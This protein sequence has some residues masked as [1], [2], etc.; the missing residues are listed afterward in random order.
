MK[1]GD[2]VVCVSKPETNVTLVIG[3]VYTI[4]YM[5]DTFV[6]VDGN[7][8]RNFYP[9]RFKKIDDNALNRLLYPEAFDE[10]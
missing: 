9:I 6:Y 2:K 7:L 3:N 8:D 10:N 5:C 4:R 1:V